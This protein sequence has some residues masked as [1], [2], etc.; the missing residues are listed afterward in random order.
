[1]FHPPPLFQTHSA[2]HI[3]VRKNSGE[4]QTFLPVVLLYLLSLDLNVFVGQHNKVRQDFSRCTVCLLLCVFVECVC[5]CVPVFACT[6]ND[7]QQYTLHS[8]AHGSVVHRALNTKYILVRKWIVFGRNSFGVMNWWIGTTLSIDDAI[9][10]LTLPK[11]T[12][13][14]G[15]FEII[16]QPNL[17]SLLKY[18]SIYLPVALYCLQLLPTYSRA[19]LNGQNALSNHLEVFLPEKCLSPSCV[20]V[21]LYVGIWICVF[22]VLYY[23]WWG[24]KNVY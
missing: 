21:W 23:I 22:S 4:C 3:D 10:F 13:V 5:V 18:G 16:C 20:C 24:P 7:Y 19:T 11:V 1:M 2:N 17:L 12:E 9:I 6:L 8:V 15:L 14:E